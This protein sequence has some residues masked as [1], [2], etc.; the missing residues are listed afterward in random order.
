MIKCNKEQVNLG[1]FP[2]GTLLIKELPP[3]GEKAVLTWLYENNDY[4][5]ICCYSDSGRA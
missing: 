3:Q 2:D 5:T 1:H 4:S